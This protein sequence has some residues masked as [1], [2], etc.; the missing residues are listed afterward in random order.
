MDENEERRGEGLK[1]DL[2]DV[3]G[4]ES[5]AVQQRLHVLLRPL[6][7]QVIPFFKFYLFIFILNLFHSW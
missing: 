1:I 3:L 2:S 6:Q 5:S 7:Q 4:E